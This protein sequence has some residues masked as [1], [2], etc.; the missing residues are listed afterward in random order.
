MQTLYINGKYIAQPMT[1]VQRFAHNLVLALDKQGPAAGVSSTVLLVPATGSLTRLQ[2][3]EV[4]AVGKRGMTLHQWEQSVL[5]RAARGGLLLNL[6]GSGPWLGALQASVLHDAAVFDHPEAYTAAFVFW[7]RQLFRRRARRGG[8]LFT[9]S[10]DA[11]GRLARALALSPERI[12]VVPNGG[13][14]L[15]AV[16]ADD[17]LLRR[18]GLPARPYMLAVA[19]VSRNKNLPRLVEAFARLPAA[20]RP[21]LVLAG[22]QAAAGFLGQG[23]TVLPDAVLQIPSP[24]DATLKA[25]YQNAIALVMPSLYEGFGLPAL[26]A[27]RLGCPVVAADAAALPEVCANAAVYVDPTSVVSIA[28]GMYRML[29]EPGLRERLIAAGRERARQFTWEASA[30]R[31][32]A[33]LAKVAA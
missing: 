30:H 32:Q 24:S 9:V 13:D 28:H 4:R 26:E 7:Y 25:L 14:H 31:L 12:V 33:A 21:V 8:P 3:I 10:Q 17:S 1:G 15:D 29:S 22:G 5:P 19:S 27:M 16:P 2:S 6:A 11:R 23:Q 20:G 18:Y